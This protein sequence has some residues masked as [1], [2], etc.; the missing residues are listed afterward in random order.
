MS[1]FQ[2]HLVEEYDGPFALLRQYD[3]DKWVSNYDVDK[4]G[5]SETTQVPVTL[6]MPKSS[7]AMHIAIIPSNHSTTGL[8]HM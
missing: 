4:A 7:F 5:Q 8:K 1:S 3:P 2:T 6:F